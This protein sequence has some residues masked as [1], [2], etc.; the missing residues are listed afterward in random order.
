MY[1]SKEELFTNDWANNN[2]GGKTEDRVARVKRQD[3]KRSR[4]QVQ[5]RIYGT[6]T[7]KQE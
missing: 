7:T 2:G 6:F 1:L 5:H 4:D 3:H